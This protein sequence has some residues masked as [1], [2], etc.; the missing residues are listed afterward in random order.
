MHGPGLGSVLENDS[1]PLTYTQSRQPCGPALVPSLKIQ[2]CLTR[3]GQTWHLKLK[4]YLLSAR[5][6]RG[7]FA[8]DARPLQGKQPSSFFQCGC[9]SPALRATPSPGRG[10]GAR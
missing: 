6:E 10:V 4:P 9:P 3:H 7:P 2:Q 1:R 5:V 8:D